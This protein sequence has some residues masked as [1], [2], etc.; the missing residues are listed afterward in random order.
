MFPRSYFAGRYFAPRYYPDGVPAAATAF[1]LA[2]PTTGTA[3]VVSSPF[4]VTP[5]GATTGTFTPNV[6]SHTSFV[7][8]TLTW[9]GDAGAKTF[10]ALKTDVGTVAING[11]FSDGLIP[12]ASILYTT[13][14]AGG[15]SASFAVLEFVM[16]QRPYYVPLSVISYGDTDSSNLPPE[17]QAIYCGGAGIVQIV[18]QNGNTV[19]HTVA[20]GTILPCTGKRVASTTTVGTGL[21]VAWG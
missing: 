13:A 12:P 14:A 1:T 21:L 3:G 18:N 4:T 20:V 9:T 15:G 11:T 17:T 7:P 6:V 10:Q 2:G 16:S 5:N 19:P 8:T